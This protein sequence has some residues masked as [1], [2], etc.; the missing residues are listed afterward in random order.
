[1]SS[2][3]I[4]AV[5]VGEQV[6]RILNS[7]EQVSCHSVFKESFNL[8]IGKYLL[9]ISN[10]KENVV[11]FGIQLSSKNYQKIV[12]VSKVGVW[13]IKDNELYINDI[14]INLT[15]VRPIKTS[16]AKK[17]VLI[18]LSYL[19]EFTSYLKSTGLDFFKYIKLKNKLN[20]KEIRFLIGRGS[21]LTPSGDDFLVGVLAVHRVSPLL[22]LTILDEI[23][24]CLDEKRTTDVSHAYLKSALSGFFSSSICELLSS[25]SEKDELIKKLDNLSEL[26][27]TSGRDL[28]SGIYFALKMEKEKG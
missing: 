22:D 17:D 7:N 24:K 23:E 8:S 15:L 1:M 14:L 9:H 10:E 26:G 19:D 25:L 6:L 21:G 13:S 4:Y 20:T 28:I 18:E 5:A 16:L 3:T 12:D 27:H 11:P 2:D